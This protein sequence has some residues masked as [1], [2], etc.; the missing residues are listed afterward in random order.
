MSCKQL[1]VSG[2]V[3]GSTSP[4]GFTPPL[5]SPW[6][7]QLTYMNSEGNKYC[8]IVN[9]TRIAYRNLTLCISFLRL[10]CF[11]LLPSPVPTRM[12][13]NGLFWM[14]N[15]VYSWRTNWL[16]LS[17]NFDE[18]PF[19]FQFSHYTRQWEPRGHF[20]SSLR[21]ALVSVRQWDCDKKQ[22][23]EG[24]GGGRRGEKLLVRRMIWLRGKGWK[25]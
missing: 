4:I 13:I 21:A 8:R 24:G 20:C 19:H 1:K 18:A 17:F 16:D 23:T 15:C 7:S 5:Y 14:R 3:S 22:E 10:G 11:A 12:K 2:F 9:K 25:H 6:G